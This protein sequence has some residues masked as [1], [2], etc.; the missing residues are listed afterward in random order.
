[1]MSFIKSAESLGKKIILEGYSVKVNMEIARLAKYYTPKDNTII[2]VSDIDKYPADKIVV[3]CTGGQGEEFAALPRMGRGDHKYIKLNNKDTV[4]LSSSI[5]PGNELAVR[6]LKDLL[7]RHDVDLI[8]YKTSDIHST[9]HGNAE[10]LAWIIKQTKP[11]FFVPGYGYHSMLKEHRDIA[12]EK[13]G[14][15]ID[16]TFV[17]DNGMI[18]ELTA[19]DKAKVLPIK[20]PSS[21]IFVDGYSVSDV[22]KTVIADRKML[23]KEGFVNIIILINIGKKRLQ[24][25][26][27]ILSRGA[28]NRR[29]P[30]SLI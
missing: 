30:Q 23:A 14:I 25:S 17:L 19:P 21:P 6:N 27:D 18:L 11:Q 9:G 29:E 10:E 22:K 12:V 13:A 16:N 1:M 7:R 24:K 8:H 26:P 15:D 4:V 20:V 28:E 5:V 2:K 3:I